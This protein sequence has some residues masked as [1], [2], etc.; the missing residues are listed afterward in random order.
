MADDPVEGPP[1]DRGAT[2]RA[3][4]IDAD[5]AADAAPG[6]LQPGEDLKARQ[7]RLLDDALEESF[8]GSDPVSPSQVT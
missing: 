1:P 2:A 4:T 7:D 3:G 6:P 8:P 5:R